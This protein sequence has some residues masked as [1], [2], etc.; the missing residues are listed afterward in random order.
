MVSYNIKNYTHAYAHTVLIL[1]VVEDGL[2]LTTGV[3]INATI[4]S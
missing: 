1:V 3:A 4:V 2:V